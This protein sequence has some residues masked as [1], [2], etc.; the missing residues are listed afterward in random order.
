MTAMYASSLVGRPKHCADHAFGK[1][2]QEQLRC[3]EAIAI[4]FI[5]R[6]MGT[7]M[8]ID[9]LY[10][11]LK[12]GVLLCNLVNKL[13][14]GT[15]KN[16]AQKNLTFVRMDNILR[17]LEGARQLGLEKA[18]LFQAIDLYEAKDM[19][20][21]IHTIAAL[22]QL[23]NEQLSAQLSSNK[24][25]L[26]SNKE[27]PSFN[28][29]EK[30]SP[31]KGTDK[32]DDKIDSG[33]IHNQNQDLSCTVS[34]EKGLQGDLPLDDIRQAFFL[35]D[36]I[37]CN[38]ILSEDSPQK[39]LENI[40]NNHQR[41]SYDD[42]VKVSIVSPDT[43]DQSDVNNTLIEYQSEPAPHNKHRGIRDMFNVV[44]QNA[45]NNQCQQTQRD[46]ITK[47]Q[48][49]SK[50]NYDL[51][52]KKDLSE[53]HNE[54]NDEQ[55]NIKSGGLSVYSISRPPKSPLRPGYQPTEQTSLLYEN[56]SE[57]KA[58]QIQIA[59]PIQEH[60]TNYP[61]S[62]YSSA[63]ETTASHNMPKSTK[64]VKNDRAVSVHNPLAPVKSDPSK[65]RR[66][67]LS[68]PQSHLK[69]AQ[70]HT[71]DLNDNVS[72]SEGFG[73]KTDQKTL[74]TANGPPK[75]DS[76]RIKLTLKSTDGTTSTHYQLGNCIGKGQF[77]S[78]YRALDLATG[79]IVAIKRINLED[80]EV[81]DQEMMQEVSLLQTLSHINVIQYLGFI[82][83][84]EHL[85]IVLEFAEN[86]SLMSTSKAFG[87][88]PE[89]LVASFCVKI[90]SGLEYLHSNEVVHCDLKAANILTTKTGD[91]KL[92]DFGVSLNLKIKGADAGTVSGTPNWMAPEV[93]ELK[94]ASTKSDIWLVLD[95]KS[96]RVLTLQI[97][98]QTR[99]LGCTLV[100]FVTGKPPYADLIAM[101]A[102]FRIVEDDYPPLPEN[103][104]TE[105][106]DFLMC[107]FQKKPEDR[108][109]AKQLKEHEWIKKNQK[110]VQK[111][112]PESN[113]LV[114]TPQ[115][116]LPDTK[117]YLTTLLNT[118][119][120][121][122]S[123]KETSLPY[124][125]TDSLIEEKNTVPSFTYSCS[126][127]DQ[128][129]SHTS[130]TENDTYETH[131]FI[132]TSFGKKLVECKVCSETMLERA[133]FCEVCALICHEEC[134]HLAHSCPRTVNEQQPT[135]DRTGAIKKRL[136]HYRAASE[137]S[138]VK[139]WKE[140]KGG[141]WDAIQPLLCITIHRR[142]ASVNIQKRLD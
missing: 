82:R 41:S 135:Y 113:L 31:E 97:Y 117:D 1:K 66:Q 26:I 43:F 115:I 141:V 139:V 81:R 12:D 38:N 68:I 19:T 9:E 96:K 49:L 2:R 47:D 40:S 84:E 71:T 83:T 137:D 133:I 5:N 33:N 130:L 78:V 129:E 48:M 42:N 116:C 4:D 18:Q 94:G 136:L 25:E 106:H 112:F 28:N 101:S 99:S 89:K 80:E 124:L 65:K 92:T 114:D 39:N 88:F 140:V 54:N 118:S 119:G 76:S 123:L 138:K 15:I 57:D 103:I 77:G 90:L 62:P 73:Q 21:V 134:K 32:E 126:E 107:C 22:A 7:L 79:E 46:A 74:N 127:S 37:L 53:V 56:Q 55:N 63:S 91:V 86:G 50:I 142:R 44:D 59:S 100:E 35:K 64:T 30:T 121:A 85:N 8:N 105:M 75:E 45:R 102:M 52:P 16:V 67:S 24:K 11:M 98:M 20:A 131:R 108:P 10:S 6:T 13:R 111:V 17:F 29:K 120:T 87:A 72:D 70:N 58:N 34:R 36:S 122:S 51:S 104:S 61:H 60:T 132:R 110:D 95:S 93:I 69:S 109:T 3:N 14:P 128:E 27:F 125:S 23:P